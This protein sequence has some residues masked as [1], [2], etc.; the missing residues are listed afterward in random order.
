MRKTIAVA[1]TV[2][3]LAAPALTS[4]PAQAASTVKIDVLKKN[5]KKG[6]K[7][8]A[9]VS[10]KV[11]CP[12]KVKWAKGKIFFC[13]VKAKDGSKARVQVRLGNEAKGRLKWKVV[14]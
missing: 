7:K 1:V 9:K 8:Q 4:A 12:K 2:P 13:Q 11:T 3:L 6:I 10:V 5:I 14:T